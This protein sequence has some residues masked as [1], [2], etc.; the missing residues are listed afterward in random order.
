[1]LGQI[2]RDLRGACKGP[3]IELLN[4]LPSSDGITALHDVS[5]KRS[6][7]RIVKPLSCRCSIPRNQRGRQHARQLRIGKVIRVEQIT[8]AVGHLHRGLPARLRLDYQVQG[9]GH[10]RCQHGGGRFAAP[11]PQAVC[12]DVS[13]CMYRELLSLRAGRMNEHR[14]MRFVGGDDEGANRVQTWHRPLACV[15]SLV[16]RLHARRAVVFHPGDHCFRCMRERVD[17]VIPCTWPA[18]TWLSISPGT[19]YSP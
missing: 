13:A 14:Q 7:D 16:K 1:V 11:A 19:R 5:W 9:V 3:S 18:C 15:T 8:K 12:D 10:S 2:T 17:G 4:R 6:R